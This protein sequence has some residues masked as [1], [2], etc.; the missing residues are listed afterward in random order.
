MKD[1]IKEFLIG[2]YLGD[3]CFVKKTER[4]N[5]YAIFKHCFSQYG[6]LKWKFDFLKQHGYIKNGKEIKE[7]SI[8]AGSVYPNHQ[9]Q[10]TFTTISTNDFNFIKTIN[11]DDILN[12]FDE[13]TFVVW[14]LDD[15]NVHKKTIKIGTGSKSEAL[16]H[17]LV[18]KINELFGTN[19][20]L[21]KHPTNSV[22][23]YIRFVTADYETILGLVLKYVSDEVDVVYDK[24]KLGRETVNVKIKYHNEK[25]AA[26]MMPNSDWIDLRAAETVEMKQ[27]EYRQISLGVSMQLPENFEAHVAPR[28]STFKRWGIILVNGIGIIDNSFCGDNDVWSFPALAMRD[29]KIVEGE[30]ICQFRIVRKQPTVRLV[31]VQSLGNADRGGIGSTGVK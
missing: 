10:F 9:P 2:S 26:I 13:L 6:W 8:K 20:V 12:Y 24:F 27:G 30:R 21:Y 15:G 11:D 14:L 7:V 23:N 5:T 31:E 16:C 28:S 1:I 22:K 3:G 4:H 18:D 25:D 17:R 29:T 19:C